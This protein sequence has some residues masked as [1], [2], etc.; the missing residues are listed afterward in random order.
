[1]E[2][3]TDDLNSLSRSG[4]VGHEGSRVIIKLRECFLAGMIVTRQQI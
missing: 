3:Y 4:Q 1:M 2:E